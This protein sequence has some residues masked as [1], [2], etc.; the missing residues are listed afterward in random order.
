MSRDLCPGPGS[1]RT[2]RRKGIR[3]LPAIQALGSHRRADGS[4]TAGNRL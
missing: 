1:D 3:A 4:T 2:I